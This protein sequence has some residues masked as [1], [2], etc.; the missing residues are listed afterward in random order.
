MTE[1]PAS[2]LGDAPDRGAHPGAP[3]W[4][5]AAVAVIVVLIVVL[6][7]SKLV[8]ADHGPGR[9]GGTQTPAAEASRTTDTRPAEAAGHVPPE[10]VPGHGAPQP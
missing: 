7:V 10:G 6:V 2:P 3:R 4:V 8:G 5:K 9:H 1:P